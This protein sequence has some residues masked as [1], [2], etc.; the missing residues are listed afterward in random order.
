MSTR[1]PLAL[2]C[3]IVLAC[4]SEPSEAEPSEAERDSSTSTTDTGEP[5]GPP[6]GSLVIIGDHAALYTAARRDAETFVTVPPFKASD[7]RIRGHLAEVVGVEGEFF[8]IRTA[9]LDRARACAGTFAG[10]EDYELRLFVLREA[11]QPVLTKPKI[12]ELDDGTKLELAP[13][14]PVIGPDEVSVGGATLQV[15]LGDGETGEWFTAPTAAL[16][17]PP[18]V[19]WSLGSALGYGDR[20]ITPT[21]ELFHYAHERAA[22]DGGALLTFINGCGRFT[23]LSKDAAERFDPELAARQAGILGL[24][25]QGEVNPYGCEEL[26][27]VAAAGTPVVWKQGG[28]AGS[29]RREHALPRDAVEQDGKVCFANDDLE[30]CIAADK[31]TRKGDPD[32]PMGI[33]GLGLVGANRDARGTS[34]GTGFGHSGGSTTFKGVRQEPAT[35]S[36]GLE[37]DIVRRIVRA[38]I[39]ELRECHNSALKRDPTVAGRIIIAFEIGANGKVSRAEIEQSELTPA[40]DALGKCVVKAFRRWTFPKPNGGQTVTVEYPIMFG[41]G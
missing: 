21:G 36:A 14:V 23:L 15:E 10:A 37:S 28:E 40:D 24:L 11:F 22:V 18:T 32:C 3:S 39:N 19:T 9:T 4:K 31:L 20:S 2:C 27:W 8:Q 41:A 26:R 25:E 17:D 6:P 34:D 5:A 13:G 29:V 38:H 16:V 33:G 12:V 1:I 35:V 30:A 7:Q